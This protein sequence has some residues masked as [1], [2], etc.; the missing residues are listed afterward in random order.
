MTNRVSMI[1]SRVAAAREPQADGFFLHTIDGPEMPQ[2]FLV[3]S[4]FSHQR[5]FA[6][7]HRPGRVALD[8]ESRRDGFVNDTTGADD[9][10][11]ANSHVWQ[12]GDVG[13]NIDVV[14]DSNGGVL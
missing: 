4:P 13:S 5:D 7:G 8:H 9:R 2:E 12:D 1:V 3:S 10:T 14:T 6:N 11:F